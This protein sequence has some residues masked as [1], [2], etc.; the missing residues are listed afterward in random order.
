[1]PYYIP[2]LSELEKRF[3]RFRT[4]KITGASNP[5]HIAEKIKT[6]KSKKDNAISIENI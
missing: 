5:E 1:M 2:R 4:K 3:N 6:R